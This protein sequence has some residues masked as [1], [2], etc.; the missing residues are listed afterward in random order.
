MKRRVLLLA[1]IASLLIASSQQPR[2]ISNTVVISQI[3]GG[4][5]NTGAIYKN[6][7][8]ELFNRSASPVDVTGMSVQYASATGTALGGDQPQRHHRA[9]A[10]TTWCRR[11]GRRRHDEPAHTGRH[12]HDCDVRNRRKGRARRQHHRAQRRLPGRRD[13]HRL[14][15]V[16]S[17]RQLLRSR[18]HSD[19]VEHDRG[20]PS[21]Q[22][23]H[24]D[25]QQRR[26]LLHRRAAA[27]QQR[28]GAQPVRRHHEPLRR[29]RGEPIVGAAW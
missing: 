12:G 27:T 16:R 21:R 18:S 26:R 29:W 3:Y 20:A 8:I 23:L 28:G 6:D 15:R 5:G 13:N 10:G 1:A 9:P 7:F 2:A 17:D 19:P 24:R 22:R 4:G 14:H 25:R 11:P